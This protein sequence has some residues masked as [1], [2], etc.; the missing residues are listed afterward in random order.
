MIK[1][2][3][4]AMTFICL[5]AMAQDF[6]DGYSRMI[7][8]GLLH[9]DDTLTATDSLGMDSLMATKATTPILLKDI[10]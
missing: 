8:L 9:K 5:S 3:L 6:S 2:A 4:L 10:F 7:Q 1:T